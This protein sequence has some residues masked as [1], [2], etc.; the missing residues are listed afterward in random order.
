MT[1]ELGSDANYGLQDGV[2]VSAG[3]VS[4]MVF[5]STNDGSQHNFWELESSELHGHEFVDDRLVD[6]QL[7]TGSYRIGQCQRRT[8]ERCCA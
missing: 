8:N 3:S 7:G 1:F 5:T 2:S 6:W 4:N